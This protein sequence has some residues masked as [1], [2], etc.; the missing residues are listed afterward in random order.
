MYDD[1]VNYD[2]NDLM[3]LIAIILMIMIYDGV[4]YDD[5]GNY[6]AVYVNYVDFDLYIMLMMMFRFLDTARSICI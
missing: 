3:I 6:V 4:N 1:D 2:D 5:V